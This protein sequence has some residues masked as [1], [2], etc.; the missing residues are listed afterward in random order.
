M[1]L[2]FI[3]CTHAA[4]TVNSRAEGFRHESCALLQV[5]PRAVHAPLQRLVDPDD[6]DLCIPL[7][8]QHHVLP[9]S[10]FVSTIRLLVAQRKQRAPRRLAGLLAHASRSHF[11]QRLNH[12]RILGKRDLARL[13]QSELLQRFRAVALPHLLCR[14]RCG[15]HGVGAQRVLWV[16]EEAEDQ[17]RSDKGAVDQ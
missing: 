2:P 8:A 4:Q 11:L 1:V 13:K 3:L 5:D 9:V 17:M 14:L 12:L 16:E 10:A 6:H 15:R 7:I